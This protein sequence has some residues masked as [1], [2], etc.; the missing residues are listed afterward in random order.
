MTEQLTAL[1][2]T[3][4]FSIR[5]RALN[6]P[7]FAPHWVAKRPA[8]SDRR[9]STSTRVYVDGFPRSANSYLFHGARITWGEGAVAGHCHSAGLLEVATR[10]E[11]SAVLVI[12]PP[13]MAVASMMS[14]ADAPSVASAL[15]AYTRFHESLRKIKRQLVILTFEKATSDL[16][17]SLALIARAAHLPR[18]RSSDGDIVRAVGQR[19]DSVSRLRNG[20]IVDEG[21]VA[22]PSAFRPTHDSVV[23]QWTA[24]EKNLLSRAETAYHHLVGQKFE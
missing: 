9:I 19:I 11:I 20:G 24:R 15:S 13:A 1:S 14:F 18:P 5:Y 10:A 8:Y 4:R 23:A 3:A 6:S 12:R 22:R 7:R 16:I 2:K 17:G 21:S